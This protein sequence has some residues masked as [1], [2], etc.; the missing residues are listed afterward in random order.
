MI[1]T[2]GLPFPVVNKKPTNE[3]LEALKE[4]YEIEKGI[5]KVD[6]YASR[7]ELKKALL[8]DE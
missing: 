3:L 6:T 4:T 7:D 2:D 5:K 1:K 8:Q